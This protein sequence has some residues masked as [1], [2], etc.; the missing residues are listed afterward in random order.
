MG[1]I[2]SPGIGILSKV[3]FPRIKTF[4]SS[5][6]PEGFAGEGKGPVMASIDLPTISGRL[7][8]IREEADAND[9]AKLKARIREL[10]KGASAGPAEADGKAIE[11]A[12]AAA[13]AEGYAQGVAACQEAH[14]AGRA[15]LASKIF[16][17][18]GR[19]EIVWPKQKGRPFFKLRPSSA[20]PAIAPKAAPRSTMTQTD[21]VPTGLTAPQQKIVDSLAFWAGIGQSRPSRQ[22][23]AAA[24]GHSAKSGGFNNLLSQLASAGIV[25]YPAPGTLAL[26]TPA[27]ANLMDAETAKQKMLDSLTGPE[28]KVLAAFNGSAASRDE[29]AER[30]GYSPS[31]GEFNNL[32]SSLSGVGII[33]RPAP[34]MVDLADWVRELWS[35]T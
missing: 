31:S 20:P 23:V 7:A 11:K 13:R 29:I 19:S 5:S 15:I 35:S 30:S 27:A 4:D 18:I 21:D 17:A 14:G 28:R 8:T 9:S 24:A 22:Q 16:D 1:W 3:T 2:W 6:T 10:E 25:T 12:R 34:G 26:A 33:T 32:L